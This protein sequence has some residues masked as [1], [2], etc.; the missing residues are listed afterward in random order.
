MSNNNRLTEVQA[1]V[2][3]ALKG[4][5]NFC[6]PDNYGVHVLHEACRLG[7]DDLVTNILLNPLVDV[8]LQNSDAATPFHDA[9]S[10]AKDKATSQLLK[11]SRVALNVV[12]KHGHSPLFVAAQNGSMGVLQ[13]LI[14]SGRDF[15]DIENPFMFRD[16][17]EY[18][19][20][21]IAKRERKSA[22]VALLEAF[23]EDPTKTRKECREKL[24]IPGN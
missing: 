11:D 4:D 23:A 1:R 14:A 6:D 9:C 24:A 2:L 19:A 21:G 3:A 15:G 20:A 16:G 18:T 8:N 10:M 17:K 5:I 22:A 7:K 13:W 12:N